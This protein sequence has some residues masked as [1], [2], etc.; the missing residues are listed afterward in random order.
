LDGTFLDAETY[1]YQES[2]PA[3]RE[4]L[5]RDL[6]VVF[7]SSKTDAEIRQLLGELGLEIPFIAENGGGIFFPGESFSSGLA[8]LAQE[9][10]WRVMSLGRD[11]VRLVEIFREV[12]GE[13]KLTLRG[14]SDMSVEEVAERCSMS[15]EGAG[16]AVQ[17]RYDEPFI[18]ENP[19]QDAASRLQEAVR[20]RGLQL[21]RGGRF[22]HL[23]GGNDKGAAVRR[24][25]EFYMRE[26]GALY[27]LG[28]G[29]SANDIPMLKTVT[30]PVLVQKPGGQFDEAVAAALPN[31]I[32]APGVG[33]IGWSR[34]V[35]SMLRTLPPAEGKGRGKSKPRS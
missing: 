33:P 21:T 32:R 28:F 24:L 3:L 7:C 20:K 5:R 30:Q 18:L 4:A 19:S 11:Y 1:S 29:D 2:L 14:F 8:D 9:G 26:F 13:L 15:I 16:L 12:R 25:D 17:R 22:F 34:V 23:T 35:T 10:S 27:T 31:L 6:A